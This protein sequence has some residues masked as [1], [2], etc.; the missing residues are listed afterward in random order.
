MTTDPLQEAWRSQP[1]PAVDIDRLVEEFR[2]G[3][4]RFETMIYWR[5]VREVVVGLLL[6]PIWVGMGVGIGLPWTWYLVIPGILSHVA[7][8]TADQLRRRRPRALPG[9]SLVRGVE[10]SLADVEHQVWLLRN[11]HW[12]SLL[13][14]AVPM[15]VFVAHTFWKTSRGNVWGTASA[16]F[17]ATV[18][19]G[20]V[21]TWIYWLNQQAVRSTLEPRRRELATL[22]KSLSDEP[23]ADRPRPD[24]D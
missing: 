4:E 17:F 8:M 18:V 7:F 10:C 19:V 13:P 3:R 23:T 15:L 20:V 2:R 1:P 24:R 21:Y 12:F 5:D 9:D 22:L 6:L 14:L 11:V 16:T